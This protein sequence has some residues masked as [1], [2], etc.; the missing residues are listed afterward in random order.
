MRA[1]NPSPGLRPE[2]FHIAG[3]TSSG[4]FARFAR[5]PFSDSD[6]RMLASQLL[7]V[8]SEA[9]LDRVL[10]DL[11]TKAQRGFEPDTSKTVGALEGLLKAVSKKALP[12]LATA[13]GTP[14][15]GPERNAT[16]GN[17]GSLLDHALRAKAARISAADPEL[18]RCRQLFEK[19]RQFVR[20]A[21][22]ATRA[23]AAASPGGAPVA[24]AQKV[25][26]DSARAT[27]ARIPL[28]AA[29]ARRLAEGL[30]AGDGMRSAPLATRF[31]QSPFAAATASPMPGATP[32]AEPAAS[33]RTAQETRKS[34]QTLFPATA[35]RPE[36]QAPRFAEPTAAATKPARPGRLLRRKSPTDP[37]SAAG[38][39]CSICELP[40][41]SCRCRK[42]GRTG[43]WIRDG[44][45]IVVN[46]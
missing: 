28:S 31:A 40:A 14:S 24:V 27:L 17:L 43:R 37:E 20:V 38:R 45:S 5:A 46:C 15:G 6:E 12:S 42:I 13:V 41:E 34:A 26:G 25:L 16:A 23:A 30:P 4:F 44:T 18:Q 7:E 36:A 1:I 3:P 10:H 9:D 29:T 2:A 21:G 32:F 19:Y 33:V 39:V 22:K 8:A 11:S 35:L